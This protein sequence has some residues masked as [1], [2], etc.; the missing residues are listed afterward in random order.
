M[1][2]IT[3]NMKNI[4]DNWSNTRAKRTHTKMTAWLQTR[5]FHQTQIPPDP[6]TGVTIALFAFFAIRVATVKSLFYL[7][8]MAQTT[9]LVGLESSV[10]DSDSFTRSVCV[11]LHIYIY[12]YICVCVCVCVFQQEKGK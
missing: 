10:A 8:R 12:I 1:N 5:D 9:Q 3:L 4:H 11:C 6:T 2:K 7:F